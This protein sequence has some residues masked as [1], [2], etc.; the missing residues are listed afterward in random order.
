MKKLKNYAP[1]LLMLLCT[2]VF[3]VL[4]LTGV[5]DLKTIPDLVRDRPVAAAL[6]VLL[7][8]VAKG[9]SG[10]VVYN[11]LVV[12]VSLIFDLPAALLLNGLGT[13]ISL[14]ISYFIGYFTKTESLEAKLDKHPKIRRYFNTTRDYGFVSCFAIHLLGLNMEVLGVLFGMMRVK[15]L[16]YLVSSWIAIIP[17][18]VC[19]SI[20]GGELSLSSPAFWVALAINVPM[21]LFGF[22]YTKRK[23]LKKPGQE[24]APAAEAVNPPAA[25]PTPPPVPRDHRA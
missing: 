10:V 20:A 1:V 7:L 13:A 18:M 22:I 2:V 16:T 9:F 19:L 24:V 12:V 14:S 21:I 4:L 11:V 15:Y 8:F 6:L 3:G 5:I 25:S 23:L 17:G